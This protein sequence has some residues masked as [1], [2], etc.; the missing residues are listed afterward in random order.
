MRVRSR[1]LSIFLAVSMVTLLVAADSASS[2]YSK[3]EDAEA[4]QDYETAYADFL[5]AYKLK[6][7][8]AAYR[9]SMERTR[10]LAGAAHVK[11]GLQLRDSGK[12]E[13]ALAEFQRALAIDPSS[14]IAEQEI[15]RTKVMMQSQQEKGA[16]DITGPDVL[17]KR[18]EAAGGPIELQPISDT[19]ITLKL[20]EDSKVIYDTIGKLAGINV[21]FDPDYISKRVH[22]ELNNVT[23]LEALQIVALESKTFWRPVTTNTIFVA[24]DTPSKRK[25]L[26]QNVIRTFYLSNL[27]QPTELQDVVNTM[28]TILDVSRVTQIPSQSAI[29][30]R[31]SPDQVALADKI[32]GDLDKAKPEVVVDVA[33]MQIT[34]SKIRDLGIQ[35]PASAT[36]ALTNNV[37]ST[38]TTTSATTASGNSA[39][40]TSGATTGTI[41]LNSFSHLNATD[42]LVTIPSATLNASLS[43]SNTKILQNP[44]I[45]AL[46]GQKATLK[47]GDR[48]PV[49]TG[50]F[51]PGIGGVGIN[52]LVNTQFQY[53]DVGVNIDITPRVH[54][55]REVTLKLAMDVSSVTS[56]TNIGG[57]SQPVIGQR[58]IEHEIRLKEGESN[59]LGGLLEDDDIKNISGFPFLASIPFFRYFFSSE[60][61]D[62]EHNEIVF[63]LTPHVVRSQELTALNLRPIDIGTANA[64]DL[65]RLSTSKPP[66]PQPG[67]SGQPA[68]QPRQGQPGQPATP[69][70]V[71]QSQNTIP[72]NTAVQ[73]PGTGQE[74]VLSFD[75]PQTT[76]TL[77]STFPVNIKIAG[78]QNV[79][80]VPL[81]VQ[82]NPQMLQLENVSNGNFLSQDGQAVAVVHRDDPSSGT[83]QISATRP[84]NAGGVSGQGTVFTLTF[85]AKAAG[86]GQVAISR[87]G[88]KDGNM[89]PI[90]ASG[91]SATIVVK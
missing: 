8:N 2:L 14:F 83:L 52:P 51:Q 9:A 35:P 20:T 29:V 62:K 71:P 88:L 12:L 25:E 74:P 68:T 90:S 7:K 87:A 21:L 45:R 38:S 43:D 50:S 22:V 57:I 30:V 34:R 13:E 59:L 31:G 28:R 56:T 73:N 89:Q 44:Q 54:A 37:N 26:E 80:S 66:G 11:R 70:G 32:I 39:T 76:Q 82:Y 60:H 1:L 79:Y 19:P 17:S 67:T 81:M 27:A 84:P 85:L 10:F 33:I 24:A 48:V 58:K 4:R 15:R 64:I 69:G 23:L 46:D 75:P 3:G 86:E 42:F 41:S 6:P 47:I 49:A 40:V 78:A 36:V 16:T 77:G 63:V 53:I 72:G 91:T 65:R 55:N 61:T 5:Q 18:I